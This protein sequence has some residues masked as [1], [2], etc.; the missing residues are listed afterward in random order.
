MKA[1]PQIILTRREA[2]ELRARLRKIE[3]YA[4]SNRVREHVRLCM[5]TLKKGE[6]RAAGNARP[7]RQ[8]PIPIDLNLFEPII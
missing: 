6:R 5:W 4:A 2:D 1:Q 8:A 3:D 7:A